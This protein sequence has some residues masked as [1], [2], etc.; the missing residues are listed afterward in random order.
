MLSSY[1]NFF[2][3]LFSIVFVSSSCAMVFDNQFFPLLQKPFVTVEG[4]F[5]HFAP[6]FFVTTASSAFG[7]NE[8]EIGLPEIYGTLDQQQNVFDLGVLAKAIDTA[9]KPNPIADL[10][11]AKI[12]YKLDGKIQ[13]QGLA[14]AYR[15]SL[16][17]DIIAVGVDFFFMRV[18]SRQDFFLN[19]NNASASITD[20]GEREL[21][22]A[23]RKAFDTLCLLKNCSD[24]VGIGDVDAYFRIGKVWD[25]TLKFKKIDAGLRG[26]ILIPSGQERELNSPASVPFG[27]DGHW[28]VYGAIDAE[29]EL[30]EDMKAGFLVRVSKRFANTRTRRV[31]VEGEPYI[32]GALIDSFEV[33]PGPTFVFS[34]YVALEHI[35][36]GLGARINYTLTKHFKD[37]WTDKRN[38]PSDNKKLV[39]VKLSEI[40]A[41]SSWG[42]DYFTLN[43]FYDFGKVKVKRQFE[44]IVMVAWDI[45]SM[46]FVSERIPKTHKV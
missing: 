14:F 27:G 17:K 29:F 7:K 20:L 22:E 42:S 8:E 11:G 13:A 30:K 21:D 35:R 40:E 16:Y 4:R 24:Q 9:Q 12:P 25:Y 28:G 19:K 18:N 34:P 39:P 5:S 15:Q 33:N 6:S 10:I 45:P 38:K 43:V 2:T 46:I 31:T 32:F 3:G 41:L 23:R 37:T 1:R 44:P 36:K 26:G